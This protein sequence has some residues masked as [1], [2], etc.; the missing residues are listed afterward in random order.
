MKINAQGGSKTAIFV[1]PKKIMFMRSGKSILLFL[2]TAVIANSIFAQWNIVSTSI[3]GKLESV[4]FTSSTVGFTSGAF[5]QLHKTTDGG[6]TWSSLGSTA[7][8]DIFFYD[9][10]TGYAAGVAGMGTMKKTTNGGTSW[11]AITPPNSSSV[12]GVYATSATTV[13]FI[14]TDAKVHKSTNSGTSFS[15]FNLPSS[16]Y[17]TDIFFTDANT[18]YITDQ[19][20]KIWKTTN[21]GSSWSNIYSVAGTMMNAVHF[22]D[23]NNGY[24]AAQGGKVYKTTNAGASWTLCTTGYA[25]SLYSI[26]FWDVN[27]G[28]AAG[29][30]GNIL[31]TTNGGNS[32]TIESTGTTRSIYSIYYTSA[33]SAVA[34]GDSGLV[35]RNVNLSGN[36]DLSN[37]LE[38]EVTVFPNPSDGAFNLLST[39]PLSESEVEVYN[40]HGEIVAKFNMANLFTGLSIDLSSHPSGNYFIHVSTLNGRFTKKVVIK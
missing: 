34:V 29:M 36:E 23:A 9:A 4:Y 24:V 7:C 20:T 5:N 26:R 17:P 32:W 18:G 25:Y 10:N 30:G 38:K 3:T 11:T 12:W 19:S 14:A 31:R 28:L 35:V 1:C 33:T 2:L 21:G 8:K 6:A 16:N 15:T 37:H 40:S 39:N 22:V 27:N 13:Y